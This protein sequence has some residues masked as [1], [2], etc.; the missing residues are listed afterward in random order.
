ML[1]QYFILFVKT[2]V[3]LGQWRLKKKIT[4]ASCDL[5]VANINLYLIYFTWAAKNVGQL[6]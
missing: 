4:V 1:P 3:D 2:E 5:Q 6:F